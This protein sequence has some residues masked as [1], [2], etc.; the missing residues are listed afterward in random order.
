M[1]PTAAPDIPRPAQARRTQE[2]R[3]T[4]T[5]KLL[6]DATI[7]SLCELGYAGTTTLE[8]ERRAGVSRGA[9][10]HH[11]DSKAAL[12]A[13][14]VDY[15][16]DQLA[17]QYDQAFA[18]TPGR[19]SDRQ[20]VRAGLHTLWS[21]YQQPHYTARGIELAS[22]FAFCQGKLTQKILKYPSQYIL[23]FGFFGAQGGRP[24]QVYQSSQAGFI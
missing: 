4:H 8:V 19:R 10:I 9:R 13:G 15:L 22:L 1:S 16:Y 12:L 5:R 2:Q 3:R 14:A 7:A 6:L 18:P 24:D 11:F 17:T 23:A 21:I 20:R